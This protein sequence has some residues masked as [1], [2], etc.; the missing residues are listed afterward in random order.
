M[1]G[2]DA[3]GAKLIIGI[4]APEH[5]NSRNISRVAIVV[6]LSIVLRT[7][8]K[9]WHKR[10]DVSIR[11]DTAAARE[12]VWQIP[13]ACGQLHGSARYPRETVAMYVP[14]PSWIVPVLYTIFAETNDLVG[15]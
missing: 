2:A 6:Y 8:R 9:A 3:G 1:K 12:V 13:Q 7:L 10:A 15:I 11:H 5:L 4:I 14:I